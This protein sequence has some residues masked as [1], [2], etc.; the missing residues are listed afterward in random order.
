[1]KNTLSEMRNIL[2]G[3]NRVNKDEDP[4]TYIK[5]EKAKDTQSEW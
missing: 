4:M 5:D 3:I 1:M 2:N